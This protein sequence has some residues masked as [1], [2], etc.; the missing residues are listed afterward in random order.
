M[1][2]PGAQR[3]LAAFDA[4]LKEQEDALEADDAPRLLRALSAPRPEGV[5][6]L[7]E[8]SREEVSELIQR[9]QELELR[10][11]TL[12]KVTLR[13]LTADGNAAAQRSYARAQTGGEDR[14]DL[15]VRL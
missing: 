12:R 10:I 5:G 14:P 7:G 13:A 6:D 15:D 3:A 1:N 2:R 11:R 9:S 4:F 8:L